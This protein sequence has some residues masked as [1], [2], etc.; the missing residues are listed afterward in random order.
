MAMDLEP[1]NPITRSHSGA[2]AS[3][4]PVK[5]DLSSFRNENGEADRAAPIEDTFRFFADSL[6]DLVWSARPDG[7]HDYYNR[8]FLD[9]LGR[10]L[11]EW[12]GWTWADVLHPD[13]AGRARRVWEDACAA[14]EGYEAEFRIRRHDDQYRWHRVRVTPKRDADGRVT[15]WFGT[16]TDIDDRKRAEETTRAG[17]AQF[18]AVYDSAA[19]GI[20]EVDLTGLF[21]RANSRY[22]E[23][24]GYPSEELQRLRFQEITH[25]HDPP[26][27]LEQFAR[28]A[29]GLSSY[30]IEKR[31]V[32][33]DGRVVWA[34]TA[35]SLIRDGS[36]RAE[37]VVAVVE[38]VTER[39][40]AEEALRE[41]DERLRLALEAG[42]MGTWDWDIRTGQVA[43]S[44]NMEEVYGLRPGSF[45]GTIDG[46]RR[47]VHPEDG[48]RVEAAIA[49]SIKTRAGYEAEFRIVR[50]GGSVGWMQGKGRIFA[51][52]D[53]IPARMIGVGMDITERKRAEQ[54]LR[55][56]EQRFA[57]FMQHLPGLAWIKDSKGRYVYANDAA[58]RAF[59]RKREDLYG[60]TDDEVFP[61]E[62]AAQFRDH[63]RRALDTGA[64]IQVIETLKH[65]DG[66]V[67]HSIVSKFPIPSPDDGELLVGGMAI[68]ITDR[69]EM[70]AA[71]K[72]A[73]RRKD[74]FLATLA[75]ELR[76]PLAPIRNALHL[77]RE[78]AASGIGIEAERSMA[79][80]HV[81]H[82]A[83]L[84]DDLMD[85]ARINKGKVELRKRAIELAPIVAQAVDS[86]CASFEVR[87]QQL[88]VSLPEEPIYLEA[89]PTRLEQVLDNLLSNACK[90]TDSGGR[91]TLIAGR[92]GGEVEIRLADTGIGIP[93]EKL[94]NVFEMFTQVDHHS[95]RTQGGLGIGLGLVRSL[96]QMHGGSITARSEGV[97]RGSE[98]VV[99]L[100]ALTTPAISGP[101][102]GRPTD[103]RDYRPARHRVL[104]VDD[105]EDAA[106]SLAR[107]LVRFHGQDV[108]VAHDGPSALELAATFR[109]EVVI[110]D[111]GMPGMDGYEVARRLRSHPELRWPRL[112]A[113][114]G[115]G[116]EG[117]RQ[118]SREAGFDCHLVKPV[119]PEALR[120]LLS[121]P[122]QSGPV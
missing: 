60:R 33:K 82:L 68:D 55:Q 19:V 119:D 77:M 15:R 76:N 85:V 7:F 122:V 118:R 42:R 75:H 9:Y 115:W 48:D 52:A 59:A 113:L 78:S 13:D 96:V 44:R 47:L 26:S 110:L 90:Y 11:D 72:E 53:G 8:R 22:C 39:K 120:A 103:A 79:D 92:R 16:C 12:H 109:P 81:A 106:R 27:H 107:L 14:G 61:P 4:R 104:V 21:L 24:V 91:I 56:S 89:D 6:S 41:R 66:I 93:P 45:D 29:D 88:S 84:V 117:D 116:Q 57:R 50:P 54:A 71:L 87:R 100:P 62:T 18:R 70:E 1:S 69:L 25:P 34:H 114:T 112:V 28:I 86:A 30:T 65:D 83:R 64:G 99:R 17:E 98:F 31:Y 51:D 23:I 38:D 121:E 32:R 5:H 2:G 40:R 102:P 74:E 63:D 105:N 37:R 94:T 111:I 95:D 73:D 58:E 43:W 20:A 46:F 80:R 35:V 49:D 3:R 108:R 36:G 10:M 97:G 101:P 67:H